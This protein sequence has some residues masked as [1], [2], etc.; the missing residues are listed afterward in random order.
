MRIHQ[1]SDIHLEFNNK[2]RFTNPC[3]ADILMLNGDI[4][5]ADYF[6]KSS[7][8]PRYSLAQGFLD[9]FETA[10]KHYAYVVYILGNHE[11]YHGC[12]E[13]TLNI[14]NSALDHL[15]NVYILDNTY[16]DLEGYRIIGGTLWT[17]CG[18]T[19]PAVLEY[20]K[21]YLNDFRIIDYT[22]KPWSRF[23]PIDSVIEH[24]RT[25]NTFSYLSEGHDN[26]IIMSHHAP[27]EKSIH[28]SYRDPMYSYSNRG[29]FSDLDQFILDRP[30]IK[31]WTHG[32]MHNNFDYTIGETRVVCNPM[33]YGSENQQGFLKENIIDV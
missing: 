28:S 13:E 31:L 11:H 16:V 18:R 7:A 10:S 24:K 33:G 14:L 21:G 9:F 20:L 5:V 15:Y 22:K 32:H 30:Q 25:L 26:V 29:Y 27:S 3:G 4:C 19:N 23:R 8:S 6:T 1:A 2:V 12:F 17:D